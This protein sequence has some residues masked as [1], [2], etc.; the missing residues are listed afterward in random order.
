MCIRDS[1]DGVED[2]ESTPDLEVGQPDSGL[3][4]PN[5]DEA[6]IALVAQEHG[7]YAEEARSNTELGGEELDREEPESGELDSEEP[8]SGEL[9]DRQIDQDSSYDDSDEDSGEESVAAAGQAFDQ[10]E[11]ELARLAEIEDETVE[12]IAELE[13]ELAHSADDLN[14]AVHQ[15]DSQAVSPWC[16]PA[17]PELPESGLRSDL[18][19]DFGSGFGQEQAQ[20]RTIEQ[21]IPMPTFT[22]ISASLGS[23]AP[24]VVAASEHSLKNEIERVITA[25]DK[26][27]ELIST[28]GSDAFARRDLKGAEHMIKLA[29]M[30]SEYKAGLAKLKDEYD[31]DLT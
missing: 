21:P 7:D 16:G 3:E 18:S 4:K 22:P 24:S 23:S 19:S 27:L 9:G 17:D 10:S 6:E 15:P 26:E 25:F 14:Q 5:S 28:K 2:F 13:E 12:A 29:E 31:K 8:E 30:I 1:D 20:G 11:D